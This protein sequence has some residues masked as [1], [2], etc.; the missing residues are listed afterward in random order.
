[1][2][3]MILLVSSCDIG[4]LQMLLW[5]LI[6]F[7]LGL[8]LGWLL[9]ARYK[10]RISELEDELRACKG[11]LGDLETENSSWSA[12]YSGLESERNQLKAD[13]SGLQSK[14][15]GYSDYNSLKNRITELEAQLKTAKSECDARDTKL[16]D[17]SSQL[18]DA[19]TSKTEAP[20]ITT[21]ETVQAPDPDDLKK[22]EGM[23]PK[24]EGLLNDAGIYTWKE[25][26]NTEVSKI[27][28]VLDDAG[29]RYKL[30]VPGTWPRQAQLADQGKWDDLNEYQDYLIGGIDPGDLATNS[31][32]TDENLAKTADIFGKKYGLDDLKIVEG[33]GPKIEEVLNDNGY[34]TW[35]QLAKAD[36]SDLEKILEKNGLQFHN[37][38]TWARQSAMAAA[39]LWKDLKKWQDVLDA[40][41]E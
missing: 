35:K 2:K 28:S 7:L 20:I 22:I 19:N 29:P 37:P 15:D 4:W 39:G 26:G 6:P 12:K 13:F 8:L 33:I 34:D 27:Q 41:K 16:S 17:M 40:G 3:Q 36:V 32:L 18:A 5:G 24:T 11:R 9:W 10:S 30:L 23:G 1:M 25:L 14:L 21:F 38:S 31:F